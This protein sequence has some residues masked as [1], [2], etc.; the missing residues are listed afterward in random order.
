M[1]P[2]DDNDI[3]TPQRIEKWTYLTR[4]KHYLPEISER[5]VVGL[6][7]GTDCPKALE[8]IEVIQSEGDGPY[9]YKTRLGWCVSG[10]MGIGRS[11][12]FTCNRININVKENIKDLSLRD[13]I[14][15]NQ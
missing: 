9:A 2:A 8:P 15:A 13:M 12:S 5:V 11:N 7:I 10:P 1:L 14:I 3:A 6:L 4:I